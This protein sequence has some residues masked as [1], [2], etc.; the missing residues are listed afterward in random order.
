MKPFVLI[1]TRHEDA[2]ADAEHEQFCRFSGLDETQLRRIRLEAA[3][4]PA[5]DLAAVS[6]VILAGSPFTTTDPVEEK[7][8]VQRRVE[9]EL[10]T[11]LDRIIAE[12]APLL[13]ACYGVGTLGVHQGAV[14]DR[15]WGESAGA[16]TIRLTDEGRA[17]PLIRAGGLPDEFEAFVGH[18]EAVSALPPHASLLATSTTCPVQMFRIGT[19]QYATQ[20]HPELDADGLEARLRAY[21]DH[22]Y[23]DPGELDAVLERARRADTSAV[24]G[25]LRGFVELFAR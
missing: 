25:V 19:R 8:A 22:G 1:A 15:T 10:A 5:L 9:A 18:K 7:S 13:G 20:F 16:A 2:V 4:M 14:V 24:A 6:G 23:I 21:L 12:D 11:L 17:D 3:P